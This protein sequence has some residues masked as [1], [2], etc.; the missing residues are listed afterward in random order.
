MIAWLENNDT[1]LVLA[2]G[3]PITGN[4][5]RVDVKRRKVLSASSPE[6]CK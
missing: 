1:V 6:V 5:A 4:V 2:Y 3:S